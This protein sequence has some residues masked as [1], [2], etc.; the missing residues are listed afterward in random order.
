[1]RRTFRSAASRSRSG[2]T[3]AAGPPSGSDAAARSHAAWEGH[4]GPPAS[5][6]RIPRL[7]TWPFGSVRHA[8][9]SQSV[10]DV[11]LGFGSVAAYCVVVICTNMYLTIG[12]DNRWAVT[13]IV[14]T[15]AVLDLVV[16]ALLRHRFARPWLLCF[17]VLLIAS[18]L[19]LSLLDADGGVAS[20]AGFFTLAFVYIGLTQP[21]GVGPLFA[22]VA[23]PAWLVVQRPWTAV[24][25]VK[26]LLALAVWLLISEVLA[27]RTDRARARTKRLIAQA[28]TD[29]LTGLGSRMYLAD[30]IERAVATR[31]TG[32]SVLLFVN[33]DGFRV[34]NDTFG[35]AAGDE[36]LVVVSRRLLAML[37]QG[38]I[39]ARLSGDE[40]ALLLTQCTMDQAEALG[41][42][43]I[44]CLSVPYALSRGRVAITASIGLVEVVPI[45][46]AESA[47]RDADRAM[48]EAKAAGR[49]RLS[50]FE[51]TMHE[52]TMQRLELETEL[53]DALDD[54]QFE[55]YYQPVVH[56]G[57]GAIVGAEALLR[58]RHPLRGVLAPD[59]FLAVLEE[60][61]IMEP[62]G[63][64]V[65]QQACR[66][67]FEWQSIDS[68]RALSIAVNLS[69]P[70]MYSADL[71]SRVKRALEESGLPGRLLVIEITERIMMTDSE[72]AIRRLDELRKLGVR[73][74][75]DDFGTGY[76]SL[77]YLR[78][79]PIDILK[80]DRSFVMPLGS[81]HQA[82]AMVRAIVGIANA[83]E[84]DVIVEGVETAAQIEL[85]GDLDC[86][87]VQ[88]FY[89]GRPATAA[90]FADL[91]R[92]PPMASEALGNSQL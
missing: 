20:Y 88:G 39:A 15:T 2:I 75:I 21:R 7:H 58:W 4:P 48:H 70:E 11:R 42:R 66:Q 10:Q 12:K 62:V 38:D 17:P 26:L 9:P 53:R 31:A 30:H 86:Q 79:F 37:R 49:N 84:L 81:D 16:L 85:L 82:L 19:T 45:A 29:V 27:A 43:L 34:I 8:T 28:N 73:I 13:A 14:A 50:I 36:L 77:A 76:S 24:V 33:I 35:H 67:A 22:L 74:A 89:F 5:P 55:I 63:E 18:E 78:E 6:V 65:L 57:T 68:C 25:S 59:Q 41:Y 47:F 1:M 52:R 80:I 64:W 92:W 60:M 87:V 3:G 23:A 51:T 44:D 56:S 90:K 46:G 69:A 32:R 91:L 40:F 61:G 71:I 72:Q 83:L 54:D